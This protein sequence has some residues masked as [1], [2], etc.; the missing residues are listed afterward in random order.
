MKFYT[1]LNIL[2]CKVSHVNSR[3][4]LESICYPPL[5]VCDVLVTQEFLQFLLRF[6]MLSVHV[7]TVHLFFFCPY[8]VCFYAV[9][10]T[11]PVFSCLSISWC[12]MQFLLLVS[13]SQGFLHAFYLQNFVLEWVKRLYSSWLPSGHSLSVLWDMLFRVIWIS[14]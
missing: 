7:L 9:N 12:F 14:L 1:L 11:S 10:S 2:R 3:I 6:S 5:S 8:N 4:V 13:S